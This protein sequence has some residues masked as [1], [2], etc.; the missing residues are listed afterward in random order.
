[1][2]GEVDKKNLPRYYFQIGIIF[3]PK[4]NKNITVKKNPWYCGRD[5]SAFVY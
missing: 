2:Y 1:M 3:C 4:T 5:H